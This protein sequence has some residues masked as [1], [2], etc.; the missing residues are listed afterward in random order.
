MVDW[1]R[2]RRLRSDLA[3]MKRLASFAILLLFHWMQGEEVEHFTSA[4]LKRCP[5]GHEDL[6][7]VPVLYGLVG[8]L[9]KDPEDYDDE[10][11]EIVAKQEAGEL[12]LGGDVI[13]GIP[14]KIQPVC[15]TCGF[16]FLSDSMDKRDSNWIRSNGSRESFPRSFH[17]FTSSLPILPE[18]NRSA[19]YLQ[20][21]SLDGKHLEYE[22][23]SYRS[24]MPYPKLLERLKEWWV[25]KSLDA[26]EH[27]PTPHAPD[28]FGGDSRTGMFVYEGLSG[29]QFRDDNVR[30]EVIEREP[31]EVEVSF[32]VS[33][34][35]QGAKPEPE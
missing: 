33:H 4:E 35:K 27:S 19:T 22:S 15:K 7:D 3:K 24:S 18:G 20:I 1:Q 16:C 26:T 10:D 2:L 13:V 32:S 31:G 14:P 28:P 9:Y 29:Y 25:R 6:K 23:V 8:P 5:N 34:P 30:L 12:I 11:R 17:D 21:L